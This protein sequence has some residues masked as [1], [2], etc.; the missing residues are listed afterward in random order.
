[1]VMGFSWSVSVCREVQP[2]KMAGGTAAI[3]FW[4][5]ASTF[6]RVKLPR[7]S[8]NTWISTHKGKISLGKAAAICER[9]VDCIGSIVAGRA[10]KPFSSKGH[11]PSGEPS[12]VLNGVTVNLIVTSKGDHRS[13][14]GSYLQSQFPPVRSKRPA[15]LGLR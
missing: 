3:R 7:D 15:H 8:G 2:L 12:R 10:C 14:G 13:P 4:S 9:M 5:A 6:S 1:M 11:V